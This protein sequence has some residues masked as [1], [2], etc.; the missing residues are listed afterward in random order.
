MA[1]IDVKK[2]QASAGLLGKL[3]IGD[4]IYELKDIVAREAIDVLNGTVDT[5]G[6]ILKSIK[7]NA[8]DAA[9]QF[10]GASETTTLGN[11]IQAVQ[12]AL[13][14]QKAGAFKVVET[15]PA[16]D[17]AEANV[18]YLVPK[19]AAVENGGKGAAEGT[20]GYI[21]WVYVE[22]AG[23]FEELGDTD[24]DLSGYYTKDETDGLL[25]ALNTELTGKL[26]AL[27]TAINAEIE[28]INTSIGTWAEGSQFA[29]Q[30]LRTAIESVYAAIEGQ[31]TG[32]VVTAVALDDAWN[33][34][35]VSTFVV[36]ETDTEMAVFT[37][38]TAA[39]IGGLDV[40]TGLAVF[41]STN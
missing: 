7:D 31:S 5:D 12:D 25:S 37:T 22:D 2:N 24:I 23:K 11:A 33:A 35:A 20:V 40:T 28:A 17:D 4:S 30:S 32:T 41:P 15:L 3:K 19:T 9:F 34:G 1:I 27:E 21:E 29:D 16:L 6:S 14:A 38:G 10:T 39:T 18:I 8:K 36:D 13:V 26:T